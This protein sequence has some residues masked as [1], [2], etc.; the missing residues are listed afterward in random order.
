MIKCPNC[1]AELKF[2]VKDKA[3]KCEYCG[4]TFEPK[5]LRTT[6]NFSKEEKEEIK[7]E[8]KEQITGKSYSCSQCGAKLLTFDETAITFCSYCGSQAV[9]ESKMMSTDKPD[10]IIPFKVTKEDC[11]KSYKKKISK[12][13]FAPNYMKDDIVISKFRGIYMPYGIYKLSKH[14]LVTN[15][16]SKYS[17]RSGDYVYYD[18]FDLVCQLDAEYDGIS[19]DL[20]SKFYDRFSTAIPFNCKEVEEFNPNYLSGFYA[21]TK[22]VEDK[23]YNIETIDVAK[24]DASSRLRKKKEMRKYNC[25]TPNAELTVEK[26]SD[27]MFPVYFLAIRDTSNKKINFAVVNGQTGKVAIDLPIDYF[28]YLIGT[29][30]VSLPIFFILNYGIVFIPKVVIIFAFICSIVSLIISNVQLNEAY[31]REHLLDD[32]G[33]RYVERISQSKRKASKMKFSEKL[34][35]YLYKQ[36]IGMIIIAVIWFLKP[37]NDA[38]YYGATIISLFL[39]FWAFHDLV[40][41]HNQIVSNKLPQ[42]EKRGGDEHE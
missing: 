12:S 31:R 29:L 40:S 4:S 20:I 23:I 21:D 39:T 17:H 25:T 37:V 35:K 33:I 41:E 15:K 34:F 6:I 8:P 11:I 18:D 5:E 3:V 2:S 30:I 7:E 27:A 38:Y 10:Y 42:L 36:V 16:G 22:D 32:S 14:G 1:S 9:V 19:R 24:E 28:K 26:V 13:L